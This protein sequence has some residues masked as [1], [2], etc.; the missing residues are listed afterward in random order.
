MGKTINKLYQHF[1]AFCEGFKPEIVEFDTVD[2][3]R[4]IKWVKSWETNK[5]FYKWAKSNNKLMALMEEGKTWFVVGKIEKPEL[6][7][8]PEWVYPG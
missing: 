2:D 7:D 4:N 8:L 5:H 6:I 1:P 3:L